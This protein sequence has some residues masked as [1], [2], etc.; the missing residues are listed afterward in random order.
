MRIIISALSIFFIGQGVSQAVVQDFTHG[1]IVDKTEFSNNP[2]KF[3]G[4]VVEIKNIS[5]SPVQSSV[6]KSKTSP[7][8]KS[9]VEETI[10]KA[11]SSN[12]VSDGSSAA[13]GTSPNK[14]N[15]PSG[16]CPAAPGFISQLI[17]ITANFG[18]CMLMSNDIK[19]QM[20][21]SSANIN[22]FVY[23]KPDGTFEIKR[24][25]KNN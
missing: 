4:K 12:G 5:Y 2:S 21:A 16:N 19:K 15:N 3:K 8:K 1:I 9:P 7:V 22:L 17:P 13:P 18:P 23:C 24:I 11:V 25:V 14:T 10:N 6:I 20:P